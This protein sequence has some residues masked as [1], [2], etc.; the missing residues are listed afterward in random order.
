MNKQQK[1]PLTPLQLGLCLLGGAGLM[2]C[3]AGDIF[4]L[5]FDRGTVGRAV[6]IANLV[7]AVLAGAG[8]FLLIPHAGGIDQFD[9]DEKG[10]RVPAVVALRT[11]FCMIMADITI[12]LIMMLLGAMFWERARLAIVVCAPLLFAAASMVYFIRTGKM[13]GEPEEVPEENTARTELMKAADEIIAEEHVHRSAED[14]LA[15]IKADI[16]SSETE[17]T[18]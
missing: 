18:Q 15:D 11:C 9:K 16:G 14:I 6:V 12:V 7:L 5:L 13:G 4:L 1:I 3:A 10:D 2:F 8:C 17:D